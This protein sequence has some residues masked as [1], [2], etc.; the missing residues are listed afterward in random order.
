MRVAVDFLKRHEV[1]VRLAQ[2]AGDFFQISWRVRA[3]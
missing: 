1:G 2:E 3:G